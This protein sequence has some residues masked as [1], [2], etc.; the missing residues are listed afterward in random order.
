MDPTMPSMRLS[1]LEVATYQNI[2]LDP[3]YS[4]YELCFAGTSRR[5][6]ADVVLERGTLS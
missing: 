1:M 3:T 4:T 2:Y 6:Q 5:L